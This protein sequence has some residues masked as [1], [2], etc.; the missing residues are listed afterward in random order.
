MD[1]VKIPNLT[2]YFESASGRKHGVGQD[3]CPQSSYSWDCPLP[4]A[5]S[6]DTV[7]WERMKPEQRYSGGMEKALGGGSCSVPEREVGYLNIQSL[8][9]KKKIN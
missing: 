2:L 9:Q 3:R 5:T 4:M 8:I 6:T 7:L 1:S